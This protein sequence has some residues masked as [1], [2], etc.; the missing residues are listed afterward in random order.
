VTAAAIAMVPRRR[1]PRAAA[2][3]MVLLRGRWELLVGLRR[4]VGLQPMVRAHRW[5]RAA[6]ASADV[7]LV[8][9]LR[10]RRSCRGRSRCSRRRGKDQLRCG[11]AGQNLR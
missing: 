9:V 5:V 11:L 6:M 3:A 1:G 4:E 7:R 8:L 10:R 2:V